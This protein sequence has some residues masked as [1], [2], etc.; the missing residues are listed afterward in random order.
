MARNDV[1]AGSAANSETTRQTTAKRLCDQELAMDAS[2]GSDQHKMTS[3]RHIDDEW[4]PEET[5][6]K[7]SECKPSTKVTLPTADQGPK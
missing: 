2:V 5:A 6:V 3:V 7:S 1:V 4:D